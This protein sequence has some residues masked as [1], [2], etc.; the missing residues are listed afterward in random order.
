MQ[1]RIVEQLQLLIAFSNGDRTDWTTLLPLLEA[2]SLR[3]RVSA[4]QLLRECPHEPNID[5]YL[6]QHIPYEAFYRIHEFSELDYRKLNSG[7]YLIPLDSKSFICWFDNGEIRRI[8]PFTGA[9]LNSSP[10]NCKDRCSVSACAIHPNDNLIYQALTNGKIQILDYAHQ[11]IAGFLEPYTQLEGHHVPTLDSLACDRAGQILVGYIGKTAT[12]LVWDLASGKLRDRYETNINT[13]RF[14]RMCLTPNGRYAAFTV[15]DGVQI[16]DFQNRQMLARISPH[17]TYLNPIISPVGNSLI[18]DDVQIIQ[19]RRFFD[20][21]VRHES[22]L[23]EQIFK[24]YPDR[25]CLGYE[26]HIP[27]VAA[28]APDGKTLLIKVEKNDYLLWDFRSHRLRRR[29]IRGGEALFSPNGQFFIVRDEG[30]QVWGIRKY[31]PKLH[32]LTPSQEISDLFRLC[33]SVWS[34]DKSMCAIAPTEEALIYNFMQMAKRHGYQ[35]AVDDIR[36]RVIYK[37]T[38]FFDCY[39]IG[40]ERGI[41]WHD[42]KPQ[43]EQASYQ[44]SSGSYSMADPSHFPF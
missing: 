38:Y 24:S 17:F 43:F 29:H 34:D 10:P 8:D 1:I 39:T 35:F 12:L 41:P 5:D 13:H 14:P 18:V 36:K 25:C 33:T 23:P 21:A 2:D 32:D 30:L 40:K 19:E 20:G 31:L 28:I 11:T 42:L 15:S 27:H 44:Y 16:F 7:Q 37:S 26:G 3:V 4:Y 22:Q 6:L 9:L